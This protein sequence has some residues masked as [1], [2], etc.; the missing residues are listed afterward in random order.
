MQ[1]SNFYKDI[2]ENRAVVVTL[3]IYVF[4]LIMKVLFAF[5]KAGQMKTP[6]SDEL[7]KS[8]S[9]KNISQAPC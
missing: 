7:F 4:N 5:L 8:I 9:N 3:A 6:T 2:N 1:K